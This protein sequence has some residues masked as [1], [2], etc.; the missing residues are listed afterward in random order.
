M[1]QGYQGTQ[2]G[3][4]NGSSTG[5]QRAASGGMNPS[6]TSSGTNTQRKPM[7]LFSTLAPFVS[8]IPGWGPIAG[9]LMSA[10]GGMQSQNKANSAAQTAQGAEGNA[11]LGES[12]IASQLAGPPDYSGIVKAEQSGINTLK[13][14]VGGVA[15][16]NSVIGQMGGQNIQNAIQGANAGQDA[17]LGQAAGIEQNVSSSYNQIGQQAGKAAASQGNPFSLFSN[18]LSGAGGLGGLFGGGSGGGLSA[19]SGSLADAGGS[20]VDPGATATFGA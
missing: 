4:T 11:L 8:M 5:M 9:G 6:P 14:G 20:I 17:R 12:N 7:G 10:V 18:A 1:S 13:S 3:L 15:N 2:E 16:P 19:S